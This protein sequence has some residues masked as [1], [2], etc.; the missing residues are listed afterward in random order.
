VIEQD[1]RQF[2][3]R[4]RL[5]QR[6]IRRESLQVPGLPRTAMQVLGAVERLS[7]EGASGDPQPGQIA[8][9]LHMTSSNVAA[10]LRLLEAAGHVRREKNS[11]DARMVAVSITESGRGVVADFRKERDG[12]F[13]RAVNAVLSKEEQGLLLEAGHLLERLAEYEPS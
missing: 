11:D 9:D 13:G 3:A 8:D 5:L 4:L 6:R 2:R 1:V 7:G 12:W 10:A